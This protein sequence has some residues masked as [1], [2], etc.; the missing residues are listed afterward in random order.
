MFD[1]ISPVSKN[2]LY[3]IERPVRIQFNPIRRAA[4]RFDNARGRNIIGLRG[5]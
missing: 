4:W 3:S 5:S 2:C 1:A